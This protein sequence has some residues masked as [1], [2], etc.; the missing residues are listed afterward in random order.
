[1]IYCV[2]EE[3]GEA[4]YNLSRPWCIPKVW[5]RCSRIPGG[6]VRAT[7]Q[8][9]RHGKTQTCFRCRYGMEAAPGG[10]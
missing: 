6:N 2:V 10:A 7:C 8:R 5:N 1:L 3:A 9:S 4:D